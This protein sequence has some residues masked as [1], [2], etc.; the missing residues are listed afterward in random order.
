MYITNAASELE[1][2]M[3]FFL[4]YVFCRC[5][6]LCQQNSKRC[7]PISAKLFKEVAS[8]TGNKR[9]DSDVDAGQDA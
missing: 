8:A 9:V 1:A 4:G 7:R 3:S 5:V 6:F 2:T